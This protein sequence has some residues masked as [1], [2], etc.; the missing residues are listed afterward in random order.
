MCRDTAKRVAPADAPGVPIHGCGTPATGPSDPPAITTVPASSRSR[1]GW[2]RFAR[3]GLDVLNA[4]VLDAKGGAGL[5][6]NRRGKWLGVSPTAIY[7]YFS[8][9]NALLPA[10]PNN[11]PQLAALRNQLEPVAPLHTHT[12]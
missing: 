3:S 5:T 9:R 10:A 8:S 2:I 4:D 1:W 6:F 11:F 12:L 7:R